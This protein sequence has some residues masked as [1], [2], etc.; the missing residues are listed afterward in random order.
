VD[1]DA[2]ETAIAITSSPG[3]GYWI[4]T[5]RGRTEAFGDASPLDD[6]VTLGV[7][8]RLNRPM[9]DAVTTPSRRG[10][11]LVAEDGGVFALGDATFAGSMGGVP[12]NAPVRGLVPDPDG[13]GYWLVALD[14]GV[15]A[16]DAAFRGSMGGRA[17]NAPVVGMV[18]YGQGYLMV[19]A[20]GGVFSFADQ[21]FLGSL[22]AAGADEPVVAIAATAARVG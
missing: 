15:F 8:A 16:F 3:D 21:P 7:A 2:G 20:D 19:G 17:L 10:L 13:D 18:A 14:G 6:L 1:V 12:L 4:V 5:S 11:Y 9:V 22:G